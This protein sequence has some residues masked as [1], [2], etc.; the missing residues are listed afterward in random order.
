M[1]GKACFQSSALG[2][3]SAYSSLR[4]IGED[5][6]SG[7]LPGAGEAEPALAVEKASQGADIQ[8]IKP[9][10]RGSAWREIRR[11]ADG[12]RRQQRAVSLGVE[13][14]SERDAHNSA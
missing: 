11:A 7:F 2:P 6:I 1:K 12:C 9:G 10:C 4:V 8:R 5:G 3:S 14:P 13:H